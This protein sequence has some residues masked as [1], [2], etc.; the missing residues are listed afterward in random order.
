MS[1]L[2]SNLL[3]DISFIERDQWPIE[4]S[5]LK[6]EKLDYEGEDD[7]KLN[8]E[9]VFKLSEALKKNKCFRGPLDLSKNDLTDLVSYKHIFNHLIQIHIIVST[10]LERVIRRTR[11]NLYYQVEFV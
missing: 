7:A 4:A 2:H 5:G 10:L 8:D 11:E 9:D 1:E 6:V 3:R